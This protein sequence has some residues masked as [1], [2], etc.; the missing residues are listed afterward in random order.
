MFGTRSALEV[1]C[2]EPVYFVS[3]FIL[4][5]NFH[6]NFCICVCVFVCFYVCGG[7]LGDV[8]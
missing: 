6:F 7:W 1:F 4:L 5:N 8:F 3:L 2:D